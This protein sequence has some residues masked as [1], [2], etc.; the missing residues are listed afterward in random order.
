MCKKNGYVLADDTREIAVKYFDELYANRDENFGNARDVR[1][2]FEDIVVRQADRLSEAEGE[3]DKDAL[4]T[5]TTAD[6][7]PEAE[8]ETERTP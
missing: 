8:A 7:L 5:I 4:M 3:P 6:F 2:L 1:N